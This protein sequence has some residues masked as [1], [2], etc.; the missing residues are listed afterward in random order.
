[1]E[2]RIVRM[3]SFK[4]LALHSNAKHKRSSQS[5]R[6]SASISPCLETRR[7]HRVPGM[8]RSSGQST[9]KNGKNETVSEGMRGQ[10]APVA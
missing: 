3:S 2:F 6:A 10:E 5:V 9:V 8:G 7:A 1:M 4:L